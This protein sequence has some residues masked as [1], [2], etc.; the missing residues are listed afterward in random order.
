MSSRVRTIVY[1]HSSV[2]V[3]CCPV[4]LVTCCAWVTFQ[5]L[6]AV[7]D[8]LMIYRFLSDKLMMTKSLAILSI[9]VISLISLT[10]LVTTHLYDFPLKGTKRRVVQGGVARA[11]GGRQGCLSGSRRLSALTLH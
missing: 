10:F 1:L 3:C 2:R 4:S 8:M 5:P 11:P 9:S 7:S 6:D